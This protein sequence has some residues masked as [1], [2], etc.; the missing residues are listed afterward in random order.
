ME[1]QS[2]PHI[3]SSQGIITRVVVEDLFGLYTYDLRPSSENLAPNLLIL[4][5]PNG[6]G[7]TTI[8]N[9]VR[10][11][12]S[13]EQ[14]RGHRTAIAQTRFKRIEVEIGQRDSVIA[15]RGTDSLVGSFTQEVIH[16]ARSIASFL[17]EVNKESI[18]PKSPGG[19]PPAELGLYSALENLKIAFHYLADDRRSAGTAEEDD[20]DVEVWNTEDVNQVLLR[21]N[22]NF[23][24]HYGPKQEKAATALKTTTDWIRQQA[25]KAT[26]SGSKNSDNVFAN[27]VSQISTIG[28]QQDTRAPSLDILRVELLAIESKN[29]DFSKYGLVPQF[30]AS[31]LVQS[32]DRAEGRTA[33]IIASILKPHL[34]GIS[35]RHKALQELR[36]LLDSFVNNL[37][38]FYSH[39][40]LRFD[41]RRGFS[42]RSDNDETLSP[43]KLSSGEKQLLI[44]MS[45]VLC[46]RDDVTV[47]IIDEPEIS[48]NV[49]WQRK[50]AGALLRSMRGTRSQLI[51]A[52]HSIEILSQYDGNVVSLA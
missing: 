2:G 23:R 47:F 33:D 1:T 15:F 27:V 25:L 11:L 3:I 21:A 38:S 49:T 40:H 45:D 37:N 8:L 17:F 32:I 4:Y 28:A 34:E 52:T 35:A 31:M 16:D 30:D 43:E 14:H 29:N 39:K 9:L 44:I 51:L 48:L 20:S 13:P 50:L 10:H 22:R 7:K 46:A 24:F 6:S 12:L 36:D 42:I 5:G 19:S 26:A 18:V 41:L